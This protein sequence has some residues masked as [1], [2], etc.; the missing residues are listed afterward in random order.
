MAISQQFTS[1]ELLIRVV[2]VP[3]GIQPLVLHPTF[4]RFL[5]LQQTPSGSGKRAKVLITVSLSDAL[6]HI[7][8]PEPLRDPDGF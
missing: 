4:G 6:L 1:R 3:A 5:V 7:E 8:G 2:V